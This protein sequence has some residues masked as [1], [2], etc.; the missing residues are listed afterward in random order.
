MK[1]NDCLEAIGAT[2]VL[3]VIVIIAVFLVTMMILLALN[4]NVDLKLK[5]EA[6][7]ILKESG[8][9]TTK[10]VVGVLRKISGQ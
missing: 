8:S 10:E 5:Y 6:L 3:A 2:I 4:Y 7:S 1:F 9:N